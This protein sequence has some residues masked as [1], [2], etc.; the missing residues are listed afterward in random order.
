MLTLFRLRP[1]LSKYKNWLFLSAVCHILMA[2]FTVVSIP[3]VIPF[4]K[5]LF[6]SESI[7]A[8]INISEPLEKDLNHFFTLLIKTLGN[9]KA[10]IFVCLSL[11]LAF[12]FR[13][14]FRYLSLVCISPLRNGIIRDL[15]EQLHNQ[16]LNINFAHHK[17]IRTG[18]LVSRATQ[19]IQE[20]DWSVLSTLEAI[21]KSPF[22]LIGSLSFMVMMNL[23]LTVTALVLMTFTGL[24]V[25]GISRRLKTISQKIQQKAGDLS[26]AFEETLHGWKIIQIFSAHN[27]RASD[28]QNQNENYYKKMNLYN[29]R[30]DLSSP[31]SEFLG[32][33]SVVILLWTGSDLVFNKEM[34]PETFF[35]F[36]LAFYQLIEPTKQ[37]SNAVFSMQKGGAALD[38][39]FEILHIPKV[40]QPSELST[41]NLDFSKVLEF[42]NVSFWYPGNSEPALK[43]I[44]IIIKK[45]QRIGITG[46]SGGGKSTFADILLRLQDSYTGNILLD[47]VD[48]KTLPLEKYRKLFGYVTQ[49][50]VLFNDTIAGNVALSKEYDNETV[51][52]AL[53]SADALDFMLQKEH[54]FLY[55]P[56]EKGT[57]LSGGEKQRI[58]IA[59]SLYRNPKIMIF[60]EATSSLDAQSEDL[61]T[62]S[63]HN[64]SDARTLILITHK[65]SLLKNMDVIYVFSNGCIAEEGSYDFL[66]KNGNY[67][68]VLL[69]KTG[70]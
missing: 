50:S 68:R 65:L 40:G 7:K 35:A 47:G 54:Q 59:R 66:T 64:I 60:D 17:E 10:M 70:I 8:E 23:K 51:H 56:G 52:Q 6:S 16:Y 34:L 9:T 22:I 41:G 19:D 37:L 58:S 36:I 33:S 43:N 1:L 13:N 39:I 3:V 18:D 5:I 12:F 26:S 24:I 55:R 53:Q 46:F 69:D 45:G 67:F 57:E 28:F 44:N 2:L 38:R 30:R 42:K 20:V 14:L 31:L 61:V 25:S 63:I 49:N 4:F 48:I 11:I 62:Q 27:Y 32:V 29:R 21:F 15:R